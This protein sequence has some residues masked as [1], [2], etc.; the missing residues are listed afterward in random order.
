VTGGSRRVA[1]I[2][3]RVGY[4]ARAAVYCIIAA[5][6]LDAAR[7]FDPNE[8][9]GVIGGLHKLADQPGGRLM[10]GLLAIGL[11]A[12]VAWRAVQTFTNIEQPHGHAP[13][14]T[15]RFG[16]SCIGVFYA[17]LFARAVGFLFHHDGDRGA[18][19]RHFVLRVLAHASGRAVIYGVG[20]GLMVFA[21][22]ELYKAWRVT[23]LDDFD[24]RALPRRRRLTLIIVGRVGLVGRGFVFGAA[25]LMLVRSAWRARADTIGTGDV[26]RHLVA[27]PLGSAIVA[28]IALGLFA[29]A[30]LM[31]FEAAWRR[32]VR[33]V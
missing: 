9:R 4:A 18:H 14:W 29:Y 25:G 1:G 24:R 15:T 33:Q 22:V 32:N 12:Q 10:L 28:A 7:R 17:S 11:A 5:I 3:G 20:I 19:K 2:V 16:W 8:P 30:A 6:A 21:V 13:R 23:F 31:I 26:L 27:G